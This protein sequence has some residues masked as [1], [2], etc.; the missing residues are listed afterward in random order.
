[1]FGFRRRNSTFDVRRSFATKRS[2]A[3]LIDRFVLCCTHGDGVLSTREGHSCGALAV[4]SGKQ[5]PK[6]AFWWTALTNLI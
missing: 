1:M 2:T 6:P 3:T 5:H 4:S